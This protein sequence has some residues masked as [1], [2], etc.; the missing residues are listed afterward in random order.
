MKMSGIYEEYTQNEVHMSIFRSIGL[1]YSEIW[2]S[3]Y[4][5]LHEIQIIEHLDKVVYCLLYMD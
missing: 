1:K 2:R 4:R 5:Y 3:Q